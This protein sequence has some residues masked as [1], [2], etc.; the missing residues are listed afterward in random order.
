MYCSRC[1]GPLPEGAKFCPHCQAPVGNPAGGPVA[2]PTSGQPYGP[3]Y[4]MH[5][6][7]DLGVTAILALIPGFFGIMGI[8]HLYVGKVARGIITLIVGL[9][10]IPLFFLS[11]LF[12]PMMALGGP[13][14]V[15]IGI[16]TF[17]ILI[18]IG[19]AAW[20]GLL[21]WQTFDSYNLAK[22]YNRRLLASGVPPW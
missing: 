8:G 7:K 6:Q 10:L 1:G 2:A 11:F 17:F 14:T 5:S 21:I 18:I 19:I 4:P 16:V 15:G 20:I 9:V 12:I 13:R 3:V 22:E